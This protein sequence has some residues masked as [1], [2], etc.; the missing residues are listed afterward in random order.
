MFYG[1]NTH[2]FEQARKLRENMTVAEK[3]LWLRL[4]K[5][6]LGVRIKPQ[7]PIARFIVDFYCHQAKLVIELDGTSHFYGPAANS[8]AERS[9]ELEQFG[10]LVIRFT[11]EQVAKDIDN[12]VME[13]RQQIRERMSGKDS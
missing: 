10:L 7:H 3:K 4:Q 1:A 13:I 12:V 6:Q 11:N 2:T 9:E 8:D 5:N